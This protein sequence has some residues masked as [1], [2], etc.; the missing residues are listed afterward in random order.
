MTTIAVNSIE[1]VSNLIRKE[2]HK[3][4]YFMYEERRELIQSA[5]DFNLIELANELQEI[6]NTF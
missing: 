5:R 4:P 1:T 3:L 6:E 2:F